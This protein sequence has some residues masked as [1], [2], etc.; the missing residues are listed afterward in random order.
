MTSKPD[1]F[2]TLPSHEELAAVFD[3]AAATNE[4]VKKIREVYR[5][6]VMFDIAGCAANLNATCTQALEGR[7]L[8]HLANELRPST[9]IEVGFGCGSSAAF[10]L[11]ALA[12][13][14]GR[15]ISID[16][17]VSWAEG[18]GHY[19]LGQLKLAPYHTLIE[20]R[21]DI[22]LPDF[23]AH[24]RVPAPLKFSFIDGAHLFDVALMDFIFLDRMTAIGGI[25][26]LDD[27]EWPALRTVAS[28]IAHNFPYRLHYATPRL[29]LCQKLDVIEKRAWT[30]FKPFQCSPREGCDVHT[31]RADAAAVPGVTFSETSRTSQLSRAG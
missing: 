18:T 28:Y 15:L 21:S 9:V 23:I 8:W 30:H 26:A 19:Y 29:L 11:A 16:A 12:P 13:H 20:E 27:A 1:F 17:D 3:A 6:N 14:N 4:A 5:T 7:M 2:A 24:K 22:A 31:T 10:L 25:I